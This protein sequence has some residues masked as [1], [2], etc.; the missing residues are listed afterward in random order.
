MSEL[1]KIGNE[2]TLEPRE[3]TF[4]KLYE[5]HIVHLPPGSRALHVQA[6]P[7]IYDI[8]DP[9]HWNLVNTGEQNSNIWGV[10]LAGIARDRAMGIRRQRLRVMPDVGQLVGGHVIT[11]RDAEAIVRYM[12]LPTEA[13]EDNRFVWLSDVRPQVDQMRQENPFMQHYLT[14]VEQGIPR[15][16]FWT[17]MPHNNEGVPHMATIVVMSYLQNLG[18]AFLQAA[19][20]EQPNAQSNIVHYADFWRRLFD[21]QAVNAQQAMERVRG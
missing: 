19:T 13:G 15:G 5:T 14:G 6:F 10:F 20:V 18:H 9:Y 3:S 11:P 2:L 1:L 4:A 21:T 8:N 12:D 7:G 17:L 16:S